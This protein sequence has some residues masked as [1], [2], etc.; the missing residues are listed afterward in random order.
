M[1]PALEITGLRTEF[2]IEGRWHA[3]VR[4]LSLTLMPNETL[5]LVG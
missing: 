3:A 5:A 1:N 2:R 4:D